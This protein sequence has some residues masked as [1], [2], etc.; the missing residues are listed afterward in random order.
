MEI[1]EYTEGIDFQKYWLVLKRHW[2]PSSIVFVIIV[3]LANAYAM[4]RKPIYSAEGRLLFKKR[5]TT[6]ALVTEAGAKLGEL[7]S[8]TILNSPLDTEAEIIGSLPIVEET[9]KRANL[10][11][12]KGNLVSPSYIYGGLNIKGVKGTDVMQVGFTSGKREEVAKVVNTL[13]EVYIENNIETNRREARAAR[14][15]IEKKLPEIERHV[16]EAEADLRSFQEKNNIVA[17]ESEAIAAVQTLAEIENQLNRT[18]AALAD[19][20]AR[21]KELQEQIGLNTQEAIAINALS[22]SLGVQQVVGYLQDVQNQLAIQRTRYQEQHPLIASLRRREEGL[23]VLLQ[24]RIKEVIGSQTPPSKNLQTGDL[25]QK[26]TNEL[27]KAEVE[28]QGLAN[29]VE[30]LIKSR[31]N[32]KQRVNILPRLQE[33]LRE[34]ERR[35][36]AAQSTYEILLKNFQEVQI[37]ENQNVGNAR[38]ISPAIEPENPVGPN[39]K[40]FRV[41]GIAGGIML[42]VITAFLLELI[43]PTIKTAK[44]V[45]NIFFGYTLLGMIPKLKKK[46]FLFFR[47]ENWWIPDVTVRDNPHSLVSESYRIIQTNLRFLSPDKELKVIV[48]ASSV[49]GEGRSTIAANLALA[50]SEIGKR[51]L[52]I[53]GDM[54]H[55]MQQAIWE[56]PNSAGLSEVI[57]NQADVERA[58]TAVTDNLDVLPSGVIPPNALALLESRR[59]ASLIQE[60]CKNYN[61][62]IIDSPPLLLVADALTLGKMSDG[63]LFVVRPGVIDTASAGA[64]KQLLEQSGLNVL[65]LIVNGV[66]VENEPDS[67]FHHAKAYSKGS[68]AIVKSPAAYKGKKKTRWCRH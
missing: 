32:Y 9:I 19:A 28:R 42:Y 45:R 67:Y 29:Q 8:L 63:I 47:G 66:V 56:L 21:V 60:F 34:R 20:T 33:G 57:V 1:Q 3:A 11:D 64:A 26:L 65:G 37:A 41:G 68:Y 58:I 16:R 15:F 14:K 10:K 23:Q 5:N 50:M 59:M 43:D 24:E 22:Q 39:K 52:L 27:V 38:I 17:L 53:D 18:R 6:S 40:L 13:M 4:T 30:S 62:I 2:L 51:V 44:E 12:E 48:V 31:T 7:D 49:S 46:G 25:Q 55:P 35:L 61:F 54:R 36:K